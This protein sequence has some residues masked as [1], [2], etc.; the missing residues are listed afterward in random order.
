MRVV[1]RL[2]Y[3][4]H[5]R[6]RHGRER[7]YFRRDRR[8][9]QIALPGEPDSPEFQQAY[10]AALAAT[11]ERGKSPT[12]RDAP[13]SIGAAIAGYYGHTLFAALSDSSRQMRRREL[14]RIRQEHGDKPIKLLETKHIE[15]MIGKRQPQA[16]LNLLKTLRGLMKFARAAGLRA[17]DPTIGI[18]RREYRGQGGHLHTWDEAEIAQ[19]EAFYPLGSKPRLALALM[20]NLGQRRSDIVRL[21]PQHVRDGTIYIRQQKTKMAKLDEVLE[22]PVVPDL[23]AAL[24][25]T[26]TSHLTFLVTEYGKPHTAAGF[27]NAFR[28]WCR[29]AGM[30]RHC[31]SHGLRKACCRRLAEAGATAPQIMAISGHKSLSEAQKYIDQASKRTLAE[32]G[33]ARLLAERKEDSTWR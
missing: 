6:D 25:A 3:I 20:L 27:G 2:S 5:Y 13:G 30:P 21:G 14:E 23:A 17:D 18:S 7:Y 32:A 33:I 26:P 31:T 24:A 1:K 12:G 10:A 11:P 22:I 19:F 29:A 15:A 4:N 9:P 16:A 8:S 28:D